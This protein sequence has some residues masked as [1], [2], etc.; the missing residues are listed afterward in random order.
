[1]MSEWTLFSNH[2]HVLVCLARDNEAR[3]RGVAYDVG[4]TERAVQKIV[5]ELQ[6]A[7]FISI[8]KHGRCNRYEINTRKS[9]RHTLESRCTVGRLLQ[10]FLKDEKKP[11]KTTVTRSQEPPRPE[12]DKSQS[13]QAT[14]QESP[15]PEPDKSQSTQATQPAL[16]DP[17]GAEK[18]S[19]GLNKEKPKKAKEPKEPKTDREQGS[20][21]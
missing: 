4:I 15:R 21:F 8:S 11:R 13:T 12:P 18:E 7:G 16:M 5:H 2:G 10:L 1:M 9:M 19:V 17:P 20:L 6:Q 3:L 14:Q